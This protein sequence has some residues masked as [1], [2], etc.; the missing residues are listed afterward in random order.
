VIAPRDIEFVM[1]AERGVL[2]RQVLMLAES[3]RCF[4]G[5]WHEAAIRVVSP[6]ADRRPLDTTLQ[7]LD[8]LGADYVALDVASPCPLYGTSWRMAALAELE[9]RGGRDLMLMLDS[10]TL[11]LAPPQFD[12]ADGAVAV[13]PVDVK[14]ICSAGPDDPVDD[15]WRRLT[16]LC[17]VDYDMVPWVETTVGGERVRASHN[18]GFVAVAR[19]HG[20]FAR[21]FEFLVRS[22][23]HDVAPRP[24]Q[25]G[26]FRIGSG[27]ATGEATRLWGSAQTTLT[28][29][30]VSLGLQQ[31][32]LPPTYNVPLHILDPVLARFPD[33][34]R[35]AVHV[36]YHWLCASDLLD[37]NPL[38]DGRL[39]VPAAIRQLLERHLP[40]DAD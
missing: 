37:V 18:G 35:R 8:R 22:C 16:A 40:I 2:E 19:R 7:Q 28:M 32:I 11:F 5:A 13:R 10:D 17:D 4:E 34:A 23:E 15:Y 29:A 27:E 6:R 12:L 36:H 14:G 3:I 30:M 24:R 38:L 33:V 39:S 20:L 21:A 31:Q 26:T 25:L 1:I 9:R